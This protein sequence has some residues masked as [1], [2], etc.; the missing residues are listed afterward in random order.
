[1][2]SQNLDGNWNNYN[3]SEF[4]ILKFLFNWLRECSIFDIA[5]KV[6]LMANFQSPFSSDGESIKA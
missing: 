6:F 5:S 1:M 3:S 4:A 2:T